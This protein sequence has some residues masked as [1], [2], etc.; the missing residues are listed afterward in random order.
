MSFL[1]E[2]PNCG[3]RNAYEFRFGG[4][5]K[6][7]PDEQSVTAEEWADYIFFNKN[8]YG[9]Q[10]EWWFHTRGCGCWFTITRDLRTNLS[11]APEEEIDR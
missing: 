2:C 11:V 9:P 8:V 1:I 10:K 5:V 3:P 4:E 7:R 6:E